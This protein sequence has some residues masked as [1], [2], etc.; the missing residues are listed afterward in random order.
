MA[1]SCFWMKNGPASGPG[2]R[3]ESPSIHRFWNT[4]VEWL[5]GPNSSCELVA[6]A[7]WVTPGSLGLWL[8]PFDS[9]L[10]LLS[11]DRGLRS[12][13]PNHSQVLQLRVTAAALLA[14]APQ[15]PPQ[16]VGC[17]GR[18]RANTAAFSIR[19]RLGGWPAPT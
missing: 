9:P 7:N 3:D 1:R 10:P 19:A 11:S 12:C 6:V 16:T 4:G 8:S 5:Q 18:Y 13:D 17:D 15:P 2:R 14:R